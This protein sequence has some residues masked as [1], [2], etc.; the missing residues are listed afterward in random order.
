MSFGTLKTA[1][2]PLTQLS[3][4]RKQHPRVVE[5]LGHALKSERLHHAYILASADLAASRGLAQSIGQSLVCETR[6][7]EGGID[8][9][10]SCSP[11]RTY[12]HHNHPDVLTIEPNE[13]GTIPIDSVRA[14]SAR[15]ALKSSTGQIKVVRI[16]QADRM[17]PAAQNALLKTLEEPSGD[18]CFLLTAARPRSLLITVRSRCQKLQLGAGDRESAIEALVA[19]GIEAE[20]AP[21]LY[22]LVGSDL[23]RASALQESGAGEIARQVDEVLSRPDDQSMALKVAK[24]LGAD[25]D[26]AD[27]ALCFIE[28]RVR[29]ALAR[30]HG[31]EALDGERAPELAAPVLADLVGRLQRL[32]AFGNRSLNRTLALEA[33]FLGLDR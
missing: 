22:P 20:L 4:H 12:A 27:L 17:N 1:M 7:M 32:R 31:A 18:T 15:L 29:D 8:A 33:L 19:G 3:Q 26:R 30:R 25:R 5:A 28:L 14:L 10:G 2:D 6:R 23:S 11:C 9:C 24:D 13:K 16:F 21:L